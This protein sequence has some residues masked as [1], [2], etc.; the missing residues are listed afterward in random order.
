MPANPCSQQHHRGITPHPN[1]EERSSSAIYSSTTRVPSSRADQGFCFAQDLRHSGLDAA[2]PRRHRHSQQGIRR[3]AR[4][5]AC[6]VTL[7]CGT[8]KSPRSRPCI[9]STAGVDSPHLHQDIAGIGVR[10][11]ETVA[12]GDS[13]PIAR[14]G[15]VAEDEF[16]GVGVL[17]VGAP[18]CTGDLVVVRIQHETDQCGSADH[19]RSQDWDDVVPAGLVRGH[20]V[21]VKPGLI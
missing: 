4:W 14:A 10:R 1:A 15:N 7:R 13:V 17:F 9:R 19:R 11:A 3:A 20:E 5:L 8:D 21:K 12:V 6:A 16:R 2:P 18:Q